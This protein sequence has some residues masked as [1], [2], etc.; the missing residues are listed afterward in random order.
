MC[1]TRAGLLER[2]GRVSGGVAGW[3]R[4]CRE[5]TKRGGRKTDGR[6][7]DLGLAGWLAGLHGSY[8]QY[9]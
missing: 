9:G 1:E 2:K 6:G 5:G 8:G 7:K 4:L 3:A